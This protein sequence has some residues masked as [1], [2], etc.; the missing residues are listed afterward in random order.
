[1]ILPHDGKLINEVL[2]EEEKIINYLEY[3][4]IKEPV[5]T[6]PVITL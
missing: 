4:K 2:S 3:I 1:M 5:V 6:L